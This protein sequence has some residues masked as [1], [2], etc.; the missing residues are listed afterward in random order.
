MII[1]NV[2]AFAF[3]LAALTFSRASLLVVSFLSQL[4]SFEVA[5]SVRLS[6]L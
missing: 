3:L 4:R 5:W 1:H 2:V 6:Q